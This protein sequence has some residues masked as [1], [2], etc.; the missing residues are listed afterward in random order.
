MT[1]NAVTTTLMNGL[2]KEQYADSLVTLYPDT[3]DLAKSILFG[4]S[5]RVGNQYHQPVILTKEQGI[6]YAAANAGA[7]ALAPAVPM[8][9]KDAALAGVQTT[10]RTQIAYDTVARS[11]GNGKAFKKATLPIIESNLESHMTRIEHQLLYGQSATGIG[12]TAAAGG[13]SVDSTHYTVQ[14]SAATWAVGIFAGAENAKV[15]CYRDDNA[16]LI[17]D[18][19]SEDN[20]VYTITAVDPDN[21]KITVSA[22]S[23]GITELT[24]A[25][26][27]YALDWY[28]YG[29]SGIT[30]TDGGTGIAATWSTA[31]SVEMAGIDRIITNTGSLFGVSASTYT[32]WKGNSYSA[33]NG[34]LTMGKIFSAV[35]LAVGKGGLKE[36]VTCYVSVPT[37]P[38]LMV[39][40]A[41]LRKYDDSYSSGK[42]VNGFE[43][44]LFHGANG[45]IEI[46][47]H[48]CI[49]GGESFVLP[50][51]RFTRVGA[52]DVTFNTPGRSDE[53]FLQLPSNNGFEIRSYADQALLCRTPAKCVKITSIA[54]V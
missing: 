9:M 31:N 24:T 26:G 14:F 19:S 8:V 11:V 46:K 1:V 15:V 6:T 43:S 30:V 28:W 29:T 47:L 16:D 2:F 50:L 44:I 21:R 38:N 37:W 49:K 34:Q 36:K 33:A 42:A 41:A 39:D 4:E 53:I 40:Q 22:T 13:T 35:N 23:T 3:V 52:T 51:K 25:V 12:Q 7:Y 10:L 18:S 48:T 17:G 27:S 20:A 32:L 54:N 5:E 45:E